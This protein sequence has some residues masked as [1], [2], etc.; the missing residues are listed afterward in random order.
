ME[1]SANQLSVRLL[2]RGHVQGVFFR[3]WCGKAAEGLELRGW[4]RNRRDGSVECVFA[5]DAA[6][7]AEMIEKCHIGPPAAR[8]DAVER[9][10]GPNDVDHGF[11]QLPNE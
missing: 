10:P 7:V 5:G 1:V 9:L 6:A 2:I 11:R 8:V 3:A 4:I